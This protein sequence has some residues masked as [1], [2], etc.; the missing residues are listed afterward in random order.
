MRVYLILFLFLT[1]CGGSESETFLPSRETKQT[2]HDGSV[3]NREL[4]PIVPV[5][6]ESQIKTTIHD[7]SVSKGELAPIVPAAP[8]TQTKTKTTIHND[9]V[10][11]RELIPTVPV[12]P[13]TQTNS[14]GG[15]DL[16][17][18][19]FPPSN[20]KQSAA[21]LEIDGI[22]LSPANYAAGETVKVYVSVKQSVTLERQNFC[23][24]II[25][26]QVVSDQCSYTLK[27]G[28]ELK[29]I[30]IMA[31][32]EDGKLYSNTVSNTFIKRF[33][34]NHISNNIGMLTL[35]SDGTI[36][37]Y[38]WSKVKEKTK[39]VS[40]LRAFKSE[41]NHNIR[42]IYT[43]DYGFAVIDSAGHF[44]SWGE[45]RAAGNQY[46]FDALQNADI[47]MVANSKT[48]FASLDKNG[49]VYISG[50][51]GHL[52]NSKLQTADKYNA[53]YGS[54]N[55]FLLETIDNKVCVIDKN[56]QKNKVNNCKLISG[57]VK[58]F[59]SIG[60]EDDFAILTDL[61]NVYVWGQQSLAQ[62]NKLDKQQ[63]ENIQ[64]LVSTTGT[65]AALTDTGKVILWGALDKFK[66]NYQFIKDDAQ[67]MTWHEIDINRYKFKALF[68]TDGAFAGLT[69]DGQVWTWG[70]VFSGGNIYSENINHQKL[71]QND[72]INNFDPIVDLLAS[73][74]NFTAIT[75]TG[76]RIV[77]RGIWDINGET[78]DGIDIK[79]LVT[80]KDIENGRHLLEGW[81][82]YGS[83][84]TIPAS[85]HLLKANENA[86]VSFS[87]I[88]AG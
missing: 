41:W 36:E 72:G 10:S 53:V 14:A 67:I 79:F 16:P 64:Q 26:G 65:F 40:Y 19:Q 74:H 29:P 58:Q 88:N 87:K 62:W 71:L 4:A 49:D 18:A 76:H 45:T 27:P 61:G 39:N 75:S 44:Y 84:K 59:S 8:E 69:H 80:D 52:D 33:P 86:F 20:I 77:W 24:W 57:V 66:Y 30:T 50:K 32:V 3:S 60:N 12:A 25:D 56:T 23:Q 22:N 28:E 1:G 73:S 68:A 42:N 7:D 11:N 34:I 5:A 83:G 6:P 55:G 38:Y 48:A 47:A 37:E 70:S 54:K 31:R 17:A 9:S 35:F 78:R 21:S 85:N 81:F 51:F 63:L 82:D 15:Q 43:N 46:I 2:I 13:D